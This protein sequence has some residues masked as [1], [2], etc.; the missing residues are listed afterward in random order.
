ML[1]RCRTRVSFHFIRG[2]A[3]KSFEVCCHLRSCCHVRRSCT[4][5]C[6]RCYQH[7]VAEH[8]TSV[9]QLCLIS[10]TQPLHFCRST[11]I[12]LSPLK[13]SLPSTLCLCARTC[14][15]AFLCESISISIL[16]SFAGKSH[17]RHEYYHPIS[18][19]CHSFSTCCALGYS[20]LFVDLSLLGNS[21]EHHRPSPTVLRHRGRM[22]RATHQVGRKILLV[23]VLRR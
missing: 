9:K 3:L 7:S 20:L 2:S 22:L 21:A 14:T 17:P 4:Q 5:Q 8:V 1:C 13:L 18:V 10:E 6:V 16:F 19:E 23:C 11:S 12:L 15:D